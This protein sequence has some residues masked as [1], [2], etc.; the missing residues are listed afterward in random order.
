LLSNV[1]YIGKVRYRDEIHPAQH[2]A[3]VDET[4][5]H[6]V[7]ETM[8]RN[9]R[10]GGLGGAGSAAT[11]NKYGALLK[12]ILQCKPCECGMTHTYTVKANRRY[13][14]YVCINAQKRGWE[15]CVTKS[16]PA[17]EIERF[18][19]ER[20]RAVGKDGKVLAATLDQANKQDQAGLEELRSEHRRLDRE[21]VKHAAEVRKLI[22]HIGSAGGES[23]TAARLADLQERIRIAERRATEVREQIVAIG[24]KAVDEREL[25]QVLSRF[26]PVWES[27]SPG[28]QARVIRLLVERVT[29][30]GGSGTLAITFRPSGIK[31]LATE[32]LAQRK[33]K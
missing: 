24:E 10:N 23:P 9:G 1:V 17:A 29:Y 31:T 21:L 2:S 12:G 30:D 33:E 16:V 5:W 27:L 18:V 15:D 25:T 7:Q 26:D 22:D 11:R 14:Y 19:V 32:S 8:R 20:I 4:V 3:I 28:E 13:R 6:R